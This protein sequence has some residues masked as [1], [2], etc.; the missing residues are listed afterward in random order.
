M[1]NK[2]KKSIFILTGVVM[3]LTLPLHTRADDVTVDKAET[4]IV[5]TSPVPGYNLTY[6]SENKAA[7][8]YDAV[9]IASAAALI[10]FTGQRFSRKKK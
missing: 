4:E 1:I 9:I 5:T 6:Q 10:S 7:Q 3:C 2:L 8:T